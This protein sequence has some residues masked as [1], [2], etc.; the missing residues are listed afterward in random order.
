M[1]KDSF[2]K[3]RCLTCDPQ[4]HYKPAALP[5]VSSAPRVNILSWNG[6]GLM[7][8]L[9]EELKLHLR[10]HPNIQVVC[11][12]E[13]HRAFL[14]EWTAEGWTFIHSAA[15]K[16]HQ[17]G[18]TLGFRDTFCA[19]ESLRWQE[20]H[21]GRMLHVRCFAQ[22]Q[23][24]DFIGIYQHM[25][26]FDSKEL[27][28]VLVKRRQLWGKLDSLLQSF[29]LRSSVVVAGDF[30]SNLCSTGSCIGH[31]VLHNSAKKSVIEER[32]WLS[33]MLVSHQLAALNSWSRK[34]PTYVHPSGASQIDWI[35]VRTALADRQAKQCIPKE[36]PIAGWRSSGH[37][38]LQATIPLRWHPWKA[39]QQQVQR[40]RILNA[41]NCY[42]MWYSRCEIML[43]RLGEVLNDL[44]LLGLMGKFFGSGK[45]VGFLQDS[46]RV[47]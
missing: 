4:Y 11:L 14:N 24:L 15:A 9:F 27:D 25:L 44:V 3:G 16:A 32:L 6:S 31:S 37:K 13:T 18:V 8:L 23:H 10:L 20:V 1:G 40:T 26:P 35:L 34:L 47:A 36:V 38:V 19:K 29:P 22:D 5:V 28:K 21:P 41:I 2:Y 30:N 17:R 39:S 33:G 7:Q 12:Q 42:R 43:R 45:R 46:R